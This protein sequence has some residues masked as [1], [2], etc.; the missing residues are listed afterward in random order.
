MGDAEDGRPPQDA[1][2]WCLRLWVIGLRPPVAD[3][4][5]RLGAADAVAGFDAFMEIVSRGALRPI[6]VN[7]IRRTLVSADERAL[8]EVLGL[9]QHGRRFEALLRLRELVAPEAGQ[10]ALAQ[11]EATGRALSRAGCFLETPE[12]VV[13]QFGLVRI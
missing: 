4:L 9:A 1:V 10:A 6:G 2:L 8:L 13:R 3:L 5:G 11:A 7:C 12:G